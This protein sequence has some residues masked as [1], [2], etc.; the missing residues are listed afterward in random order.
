MLDT[1]CVFYFSVPSH[2]S[3]SKKCRKDRAHVGKCDSKRQFHNF[4]T[5]SPLIQLQ[6]RKGELSKELENVRLVKANVQEAEQKLSSKKEEVD[7]QVA[8]T[9]SILEKASMS[10]L[11]IN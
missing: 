1:C 10:Y 8:A 7:S 11:C 9:E 4:W 6:N 3:K 5:N 2:C